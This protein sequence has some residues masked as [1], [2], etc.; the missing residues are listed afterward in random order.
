MKKNPVY[1]SELIKQMEIV[2]GSGSFQIPVTGIQFDSRKIQPGNCFIAIRGYKENGLQYLA[3][4]ISNGATS[5][6]F[7]GKPDDT[8]PD[9][10]MSIAWIQVSNARVALSRLAAAFYNHI[11]QRMYNVGITGTNGKTTVMSII[12]ALYNSE[13]PTARIG[14]LGMFTE[15]MARKTRLTTPESVEMFDFLSQAHK[16]GCKNLVMEVSSASLCLHRVDD[17]PF[18]QGI[19]TSFSGDHL[20]FHQTMDDYFEAK[21]LLFKRLGMDDW[22]IINADDPVCDKILEQLVCKYLTYG[23]SENADIRPL[24]Y[25]VSLDGIHATLQTPKGKLEIES[26]LIGKVNLSNIMAAVASAEIK[27]IS[28]ENITKV[29]KNFPPVKGRL[30]TIVKDDFHVLIDYAHTDKA[31]EGLLDSLRDI[32]RKR[33]IIVFGA[34]GARDKT[35][36]PRMGKV[37]SQK[38]DFVVITSD[39]PRTEDPHDI[40]ADII[41]GFHPDFRNYDV[42]IQRELAIEKAIRMAQPGDLVVIAGKGHEDYQI[43]KDKTI[44]F[45]DYEVVSRVVD[46]I[47]KEKN[48]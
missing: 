40:V 43:F 2:A 34:G 27:G 21:L 20:D 24:K 16:N 14:T 39:N 6:V 19:F 7:E 46:K 37:A 23:F 17:I 22:A 32:V 47:K 30:D 10:P 12:Y 4:A 42:E 36:R 5:V 28:C 44:H 29:L 3:D 33:I 35:K 15:E 13:S 41:G 18:S 1:L 45:D 38:A 31:I 9:I 26:P 8:F 48:A 25:K 11:A